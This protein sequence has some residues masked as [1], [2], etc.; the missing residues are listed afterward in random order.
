MEVQRDFSPQ[1]VGEMFKELAEKLGIKLRDLT[2]PF[3]VAVTGSPTSI[4]LFD[5]ISI[6]GSDMVRMRLRRAVE[7]LGG[8]SSKKRKEL[9]KRYEALF[10]PRD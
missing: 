6:L 4:P 10:G 2:K 3:Y 1:A 8:I 7:A 5:S 9:E